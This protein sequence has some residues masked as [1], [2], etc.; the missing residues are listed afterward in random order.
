[1]EELEIDLILGERLDVESAKPEN[2]KFNERG[3]RVVRTLG[4]REVAA[5]LLVR[6]QLIRLLSTK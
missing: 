2:V 4:G 3:Q 1:M 6:T 5:D